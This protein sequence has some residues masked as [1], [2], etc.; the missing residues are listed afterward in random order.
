[1]TQEEQKAFFLIKAISRLKAWYR[2]TSWSRAKKRFA[3]YTDWPRNWPRG[4]MRV[5]AIFSANLTQRTNGK[6]ACPCCEKSNRT[7]RTNGKDGLPVLRKIEQTRDFSEVFKNLAAHPKLVPVVQN[8]IGPDL[9]LF[10][11][12]PD[13]Q[14][15]VSRVIAW[16]SSGFGLLAH[17]AARARHGEHRADRFQFGKWVHSG[18]SRKP[19][20]GHA[21]MGEYRAA[22]RCRVDRSQKSG[23]VARS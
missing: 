21:K 1:M 16:V 22:P 23:Y 20:V 5:R 6:M 2:Q 11:S 3:N 14:T 9:L 15:R 10:R 19:Q 7:Q 18:H 13:A 4:A 8:L 17:G 12:T